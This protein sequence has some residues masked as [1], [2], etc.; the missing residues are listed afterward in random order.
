MASDEYDEIV[1]WIND[2]QIL[3]NLFNFR[4]ISATSARLCQVLVIFYYRKS[5]AILLGLFEALRVTSVALF[6]I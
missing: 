1:L 5:G 6:Q 2:H 3:L 4:H